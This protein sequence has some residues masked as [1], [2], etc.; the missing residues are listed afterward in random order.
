MENS[1]EGNKKAAARK[2]SAPKTFPNGARVRGFDLLAGLY[3]DEVL[4]PIPGQSTLKAKIRCLSSAEMTRLGQK[5]VVLPPED[6]DGRMQ[7]DDPVYQEAAADADMHRKTYL[8][9]KGLVAIVRTAVVGTD[10]ETEELAFEIE[11]AS[12][13]EKSDRLHEAM[14]PSIV[15]HLAAAIESLATRGEAQMA[16]FS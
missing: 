3:A 2:S 11:G 13:D 9:D 4:V 14:S 1:D 12:I 6:A 5:F 7:L 10:Q 8:I 15:N 16:S